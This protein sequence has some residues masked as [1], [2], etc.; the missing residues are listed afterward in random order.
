MRE[1]LVEA[2]VRLL[3]RD[4]LA[5][6]NVRKV[7][8]EVGTSTMAVYTHFDGMPALL[9]A[10]AGQAFVR[11]TDALTEVPE[12]DDPV[13]D[14]FAMGLGYHQFA[15][16]NPQRYQ[17]IFGISSP[18]SIA[19][20]RADITVTG[21]A[22]N[23]AEWAASFDAL[24]NVVGRMIAAG[25]IRDDGEFVIAGRLWSLI[26]GAVMLELAGFFG[27]EGHGLIQILGPLTVDTLVGMGDDRDKTMQSLAAVTPA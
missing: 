14:F 25:R 24:R 19:G 15:L 18:T 27:H 17:L 12:T 16:A 20:Y 3:E 22:T 13:T 21:S 7:A 23:R 6:L 8:A 11:F 9:D 2:G 4:G 1:Q 26:H 5:A 10:I